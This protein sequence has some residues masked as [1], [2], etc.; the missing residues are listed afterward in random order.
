MAMTM[1]D[2][3]E[4][5]VP[6]REA[7]MPVPVRMRLCSAPI[8]FV[9]VPMVF[10]MRMAVFMLNRFV[11]MGVLVSFGHMKPDADSH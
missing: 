6:V 9:R 1:V 7:G 8:K 3:G 2:I 4:M 5:R 10:V 11:G